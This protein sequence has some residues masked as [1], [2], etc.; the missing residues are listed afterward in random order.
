MTKEGQLFT[1][2]E[3]TE[4][5]A[6][7]ADAKETRSEGMQISLARVHRSIKS[8]APVELPDFAVLIGRNGVGKTQLLEALAKGAATASDIPAS[9]VEMY[10]FASF[11]PG[12][13]AKVAWD[14]VRFATST[15]DDY[16]TRLPNGKSPFEHAT[17]IYARTQIPSAERHDFDI[18]LKR[19]I[20]QMPDFSQFPTVREPSDLARYTRD[21]VTS[22]IQPL[23]QNSGGHRESRNLRSC[24]GNPATLVSL[25]IKLENKAPHEINREDIIRASHYEGGTISNE[26]SQVFAGY[27]I[28]GFL[29]S[30]KHWETNR[31]AGNY[32]HLIARYQRENP[33]PWDS[34]RNALEE[35]R[36]AAGDEGLFNFEFS[37]PANKSLSMSGFQRF[38]FQT[39]MT[40][41]TTGASY[42]LDALSSGEKVLI[43]LVLSS[44]NQHLGRRRPALLLLDEL[45]A[46]LHPSMVSALVTVLKRLFVERGTKVLMTS[47]SHVTAALVNEDEIFRV[48]RNGGH[49]QVSPTTQTEGIDELSEGLAAIDTGLRILAF[50]E[51]RVTI[52]TEGDNAL[53]LK[54]WA[55][56]NFPDEVRVFEGLSA[57]SSDSQLFA[58]GR[59]LARVNTNTH[60]LIVWD[61]DAAEK[62]VRLREE[63]TATSKVTAFSFAHRPND[64]APEGIENKYNVELL[65]QYATP[66]RGP[67]GSER[68]RISKKRLA[69]HIYQNGKGE[70]F[71]HFGDLHDAVS[72]ILDSSQT[73]GIVA[74]ESSPSIH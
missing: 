62:C 8:L 68:Y 65:K 11:S 32:D 60:F 74:A 23:R 22:V 43:T 51:A 5:T 57:I 44:F 12:K 41:R 71:R 72:E 1:D 48:T 18:R 7:K 31:A 34:L 28:D 2:Q 10:D 24:E 73:S 55:K 37:D 9:E 42:D 19:L 59:F 6:G 69:N 17:E 21:I 46:M 35:M 39:V 50:D 33:P 45:D 27:K 3:L 56:L 20:A 54:K 66:I 61:C 29:W 26:I 53:H 64:I 49:V 38:T 15:A 13:S 14:A 25:A 4:R 67:D 47:H 16:F 30:H 70:D 36:E 52:L 40:N 63:L 58:Y